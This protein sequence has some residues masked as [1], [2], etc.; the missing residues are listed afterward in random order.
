[1]TSWK[2]AFQ[3]DSP[4]YKKRG[5]LKQ[6]SEK[7][8]FQKWSECFFQFIKENPQYMQQQIQVP[9]IRLDV[10]CG[11]PHLTP[12]SI[13]STSSNNLSKAIDKI[14]E[15]KPCSLFI[16]RGRVQRKIL[17]AEAIAMPGDTL[18]NTPIP[19]DYVKVQVT[20][21]IDDKYRDEALDMPNPDEGIE[22]LGDALN[23][24]IL[25]YS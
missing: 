12:S 7:E 10:Q 8:E 16:P 15:N 11:N 13:G 18:H 20:R 17:V 1:M 5:S 24:F 25:W 2:Q 3:D 22:T 19:P 9:E 4:S 23:N 6:D 14:T 21:V